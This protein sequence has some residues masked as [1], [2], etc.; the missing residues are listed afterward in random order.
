MVERVTLQ[1][2]NLKHTVWETWDKQHGCTHART[3]AGTRVFW[4]AF[5]VSLVVEQPVS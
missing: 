5:A 2:G 1:K 3:T 4:V